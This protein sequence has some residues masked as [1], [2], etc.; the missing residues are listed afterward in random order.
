MQDW[1][2]ST[3]HFEFDKSAQPHYH[4]AAAC[5]K[6]GSGLR[7]LSPPAVRLLRLHGAGSSPVPRT[8]PAAMPVRAPL[9]AEEYAAQRDRTTAEQLNLL[10]ADP[11]FKAW[12]ERKTTRGRIAA[13]AANTALAA[14]C[15]LL[16]LAL[17]LL[18]PTAMPAPHQVRFAGRRCWRGKSWQD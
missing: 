14:G 12:E 6:L 3:S 1:G 8:A 4:L 2:S 18:R 9:S 7:R 5:L 10:M 11:A 17:A 13:T 15:V 16:V